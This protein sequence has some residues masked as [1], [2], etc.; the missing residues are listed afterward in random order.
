MW[1]LLMERLSSAFPMS[2][3]LTR[4]LLTVFMDYKELQEHQGD[5][6]H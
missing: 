5:T 3:S 6:E 4:H 2:V 1:F